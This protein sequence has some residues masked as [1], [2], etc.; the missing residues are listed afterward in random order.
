[1]ISIIYTTCRDNPRFNWFYDSLVNQLLQYRHIEVE[2]I[3]IDGSPSGTLSF[4]VGYGLDGLSFH[5]YKPMPNPYQGE[6]KITSQDWFAA[7]NAR[8]TGAIYAK[9]DFLIFADDLS[10]LSPTWFDR[11]SKAAREKYIVFGAYKKV[12]D[13]V[14]EDGVVKQYKEIPNGNDHRL[15]FGSRSCG[16][17]WLY[18][19]SFGVPLEWFL[20]CN[21]FDSASDSIGYED[22]PFGI[23]LQK[24]GYPMFYDTE[25][26]TLECAECHSEGI[27]FRRE[28]P[29]LT[30]DQYMEVRS[31]L[32]ITGWHEP[33]GRR[34]V[35]HLLLDMVK[36]ETREDNSWTF[37]NNYNLRELRETKNFPPID[38]DMKHWATGVKLKDL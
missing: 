31:R 17:E 12:S 29:L 23:R 33:H 25:M 22:C 28:D 30:E 38:P 26:L 35:S 27:V 2:L 14:V 8:N 9:G 24:K 5:V 34:D 11:A 3:V 15:Q 36:T 20:S 16:G 32:G 19:C 10:V 37:C 1:M 13:L 18:G 4:N 21:G 6:H 7:G